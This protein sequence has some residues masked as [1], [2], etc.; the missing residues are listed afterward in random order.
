M[1]SLAD[2]PE[3]V[4]FFSYS[5]EDDADSHGALS[6][7]RTHIQGELRGQ[8][9]RTAK[10][11]RLW[12]DKEAI[13]SGTL[14]ESEIKNA[15]AQSVFFIPIITPTVIASPYC[16]FELESFLAREAELG[17]DDLVFPILYIDVSALADSVRRQND[18]VL[19]LIAERQY[20][21]W[22]EFRYH[23]INAMEVRK[24]AGQF[25]THIRD[26]LHKPWL[27][28]QERTSQEEAAARQRAEDDRRRQ[29]A[30]TQRRA[31]EA[32]ARE[33]DAL[34]RRRAEEERRKREAEAEQ[35]RT[36]ARGLSGAA[37]AR[38]S[39]PRQRTALL[40]GTV[41]AAVLAALVV[42][43]AVVSPRPSQVAQGSTATP[44]A[45]A[46][47]P[48]PPPSDACLVDVP[49][50]PLSAEK[51]RALK[52][53]DTFKECAD[54]PQMVVVP[55]GSFIMGSPASE[56]RRDPD[57]GPQHAVTIVREF[58]VDSVPVTVDQFSAFAKATGYDAGSKCWTWED[59]KSAERDSRSWR[60]PGFAQT[61]THPV[62]CLNW[63]DAKA[64]A[65]WLSKMTGKDYRLLTEAE[66]EYA[67]RA[68]TTT[69]Y[70]WGN[71]I[72]K[73]N[74][75]CNGCG[76]KWDDKQTAPVGSFA[77]N[78]FGLY[79]MVGNVEEWTEDCWHDSYN[80]APAVGSAWTNGDCNHRVVRGS[81]WGDTPVNLRSA[82]R[83]RATPDHRVD[84]LGFRVGR[85]LLVP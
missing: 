48:T 39:S 15:V 18:P 57:E 20:V 84:D 11:F 58:A 29:E 62:V 34:A 74:A 13:P 56:L 32:R 38:P 59:G 24:A 72:G 82:S 6:A 75:N 40:I 17:R 36:E 70:P 41:A 78:G 45:T 44:P 80:G 4:G 31:D 1:S 76:S 73:N 19:S 61:G 69:A 9:G 33:A 23:D 43:L 49:G 28:P 8:L 63:N 21:D 71:D 85:T 66:Y 83:N 64:Y 16:R 35:R 51:E 79:D 50:C 77:A 25:C 81:S 42:W 54:C 47:T 55:G 67:T 7:L 37:A 53:K 60:N 14:W 46:P 10:T 2:F 52:P 26:A 12:Q 5:R 3:L 30:E 68:G 65:E 22:R 27:S